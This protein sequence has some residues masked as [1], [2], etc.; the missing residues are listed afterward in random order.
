MAWADQVWGL[1]RSFP[2][3]VVVNQ[4]PIRITLSVTQ[5]YCEVLEGENVPAGGASPAGIG[6]PAYHFS[7]RRL[8]GFLDPTQGRLK[9]CPGRFSDQTR[10]Q[11]G[12]SVIK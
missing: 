12:V 9:M 3:F 7:D 2:Q 8:A 4:E 6:L 5:P 10:C 11:V 1:I